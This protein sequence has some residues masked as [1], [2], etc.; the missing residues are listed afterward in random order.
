MARITVEVTKPDGIIGTDEIYPVGT[1]LDVEANSGQRWIDDGHAID[2]TDPVD[3]VV[4]DN[5]EI[6][7]PNAGLG[8]PFDTFPTDD[9]PHL[10]RSGDIKKALDAVTV[11]GIADGDKGDITVSGAGSTWTVN[12]NSIAADELANT[13]VAAGSYSNANITVDAQG[14]ITA[15]ANGSGLADGDKGDIT[16]SGTGETWTIDAAAVDTGKLANDA[17]TLAKLA[18]GTAGKLIGF[19]GSGNPAEVD[20]S[21]LTDGDK[22]DIT[23]SGSGAA[24]TIDT[25]AVT[26]AKLADDAVTADKLADAAVV[27]ASIV[28]SNVTTTKLADDAVTDAKLADDAVT[29][30]AIADDAVTLGKL[31]GG[32]AG[33]LIGFDSNGD[34]EEKDIDTT[35]VATFIFGEQGMADVNGSPVLAINGTSINGNISITGNVLTLPESTIPY[36]VFGIVGV[37]ADAEAGD[38]EGFTVNWVENGTNT[39]AG[40]NIVKA[41]FDTDGE[42]TSGI[43]LDL[44]SQVEPVAACLIDASGGDVEIQLKVT[45]ENLA[46]DQM[47]GGLQGGFVRQYPTQAIL[48]PADLPTETVANWS[49]GPAFWNGSKLAPKGERTT[50]AAFVL[51]EFSTGERLYGCF[52]SGD[53]ENHSSA[54][55][56]TYPLT[57][58]EGTPFL[59]HRFRGTAEEAGV[60]YFTNNNTT[61]DV[62]EAKVGG[63]NGGHED[64]DADQFDLTTNG[65][66]HTYEGDWSG[67]NFRGYIEFLTAPAA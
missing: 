63:Q 5:G 44:I 9:S 24:W 19:D 23:V 7:Q 30:D 45:S 21:G 58:F 54:A 57:G 17:V 22:G 50:N 67:W 39:D 51:E 8:L 31:A 43:D 59:I 52:V 16:V 3:A 56:L 1:V 10:M 29:T 53:M 28:D 12:A 62:N 20:A 34:P 26:T 40:T 25:N 37:R 42:A 38:D 41:H 11:G 13:P 66:G 49:E 46:A 36:H 2:S 32:T 14:R 55:T 60:V 27:T 4:E 64:L 65:L 61:S 33:K 48:K 6:A 35:E 18:G 47:A 15:A